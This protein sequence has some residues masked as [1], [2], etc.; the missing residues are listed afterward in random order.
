MGKVLD[1]LEGIPNPPAFLQDVLCA[2]GV[3]MASGATSMANGIGVGLL[4]IRVL[5]SRLLSEARS[6]G[7][8]RV[9]SGLVLGLIV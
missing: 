9:I 7:L 5:A 3:D 2:F 6:R 8:R 1:S 4:P